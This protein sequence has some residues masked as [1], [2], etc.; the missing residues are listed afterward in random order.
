MNSNIIDI[1]FIKNMV[2]NCYIR[3]I[4]EEF[5]KRNIIVISIELGKVTISYDSNKNNIKT[6][7]DILISIGFDLISDRESI[8]VEQVKNAVIEL[9]HYSNNINSIIRKSDYIIE[10]MNMNYQSISK[11][12]SRHEKIT[13][14][15]FIILHKI[16]RCKELVLQKE[17]TLSEV[18][19][20]MDFSSVQHLSNTFKKVTGLSVT[21]YITANF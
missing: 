20:M 14:E 1:I 10:K 3:V 18:A 2:C 16:E 8:L 19:Y 17:Y 9:V 5:A 6:I 11:M 21:D 4:T 13:L 12:F 15:K 7:R